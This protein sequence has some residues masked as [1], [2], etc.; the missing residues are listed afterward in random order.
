MVAAKATDAQIRKA[1]A[2]TTST[3]AAG[4]LLGLSSAAVRHRLVK[5]GLPTKGGKPGPKK[6]DYLAAPE[7]V[8]LCPTG[9]RKPVVVRRFRSPAF[10]DFAV[11]AWPK[12]HATDSVSLD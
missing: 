10:G 3:A 4:R 7:P 9:P 8:D 11:Y 2:S 6:R 5:L 12:P 1:W